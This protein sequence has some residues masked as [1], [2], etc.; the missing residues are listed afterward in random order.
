MN[1]VCGEVTSLQTTHIVPGFVSHIRVYTSLY[2][3]GNYVCSVMLICQSSLY[4]WHLQSLLQAGANSCHT[5]CQ[6]EQQDAL[7]LWLTRKSAG[8]TQETP[9]RFTCPHSTV[10]F[11]ESMANPFC[12]RSGRLSKLN[13][14]FCERHTT[15]HTLVTATAAPNSDCVNGCVAQMLY[16]GLSLAK[17]LL[18]FEIASINLAHCIKFSQKY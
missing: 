4:C 7:Q 8:G 1:E 10:P 17:L 5:H 13:S 16:V 2:P 9:M 12:R 11:T 15:Q 18:P 14:T 3:F 6:S